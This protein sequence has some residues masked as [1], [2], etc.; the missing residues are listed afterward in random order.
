MYRGLF[1]AIG[2]KQPKSKLVLEQD[3]QRDLGGFCC[4]FV[5]IQGFV[6]I[7][8]NLMLIGVFCAC[9]SRNI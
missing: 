7:K 5:E 8:H 1:I 4:Q 9:C 6:M 2:D 3:R